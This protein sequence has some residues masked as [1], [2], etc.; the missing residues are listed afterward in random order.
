MT[1]S[2]YV[3][4]VSDLDADKALF[5]V[6]GMKGTAT[7]NS[8]TNI[9][10]KFP[11]ERWVSG[12]MLLV[13][14]GVWGDHVS[15]EIV[16]KDNILGYGADTVL[17]TFATNFYIQ[18]GNQLQG[19]IECPYIAQ[20]PANIYLRVKYTNISLLTAAGVAFNLFSHIPRL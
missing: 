8:T 14:N 1:T 6:Q 18:P 3:R 10:W 15:L 19:I 17:N 16:D 11:E 5:A 13:N 12:G 2:L 9:D 7:A 20:I 4:R